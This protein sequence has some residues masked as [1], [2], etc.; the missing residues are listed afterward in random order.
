MSAR[1][2]RLFVMV[3]ALGLSAGLA[4]FTPS[5]SLAGDVTETFTFTA[6]GLDPPGGPV[7]AQ[8]GS[9]TLTFDPT[10]NYV[11]APLDA[12]SLTIDGHKFSLSDTGFL[13]NPPNGPTFQLIFGGLLNGVQNDTAGTADFALAGFVDASGNAIPGTWTYVYTVPGIT[14]IAW[15]AGGDLGGAGSSLV[16]ESRPASV[17]SAPEP[18]TFVL[19]AFGL[20]GVGLAGHRRRKAARVAADFAASAA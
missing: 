13:T 11:D 4:V 9:F 8:T 7:D 12:V 19:L 5:V 6:T 2:W 17:T 14:N 15:A 16:V 20:A 18:P 1:K 3:G 10:Q